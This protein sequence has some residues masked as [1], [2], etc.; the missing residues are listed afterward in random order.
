V[1]SFGG[2]AGKKSL[3]LG[4]GARSGRAVQRC[5]AGGAPMR[6]GAC[7]GMGGH[8]DPF[9]SVV[10][11][12]TVAL[13]RPALVPSRRGDTYRRRSTSTTPAGPQATRSL[14]SSFAARTPCANP[15][16]LRCVMP[17]VILRKVPYRRC[18]P[19]PSTFRRCRSHYLQRTA[20]APVIPRLH[21]TDR[22]P[23]ERRV[24]FRGSIWKVLASSGRV[25]ISETPF[26]AVAKGA[27][28]RRSQPPAE[29]ASRSS[30]ISMPSATP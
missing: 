24:A 5:R 4:R 3:R 20:L 1:V 19:P 27:P 2:L 16:P 21:R 14:G 7:V 29:D 23:L 25:S 11:K 9:V 12:E 26:P 28:W 13:R 6:T 10:D 22:A 30:T 8:L 17:M 15:D 18:T